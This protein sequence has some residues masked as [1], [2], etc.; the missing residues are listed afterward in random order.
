MAYSSLAI[1]NEF[2]RKSGE[3]KLTHMQLQKLVYLAHG[4][5]LAINGSPLIEEDIEAWEFG[6]VIRRLYDALKR[7]G[8][9]PI[10]RCIHWGDDTPFPADDDGEA[11]ATLLGKERALIDKVWT[12]YGK[13]PA[14]QLSA[15]THVKGSPWAKIYKAKENRVIDSADIR[16]YFIDL[17]RS[18]RADAAT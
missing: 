14:Y 2:L 1:A 15:L 3:G 17:V 9:K 11:Q 8:S 7:H 6:P 10:P 4:W 13:Y 5:N 16:L 12:T 18:R